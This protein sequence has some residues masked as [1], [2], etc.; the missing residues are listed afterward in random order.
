MIRQ[1]LGFFSR[2]KLEKMCRDKKLLTFSGV[3]FVKTR[4]LGGKMAQL[5]MI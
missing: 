5:E 1:L 4:N 3:F 2:R